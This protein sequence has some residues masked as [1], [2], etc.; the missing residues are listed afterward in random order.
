MFASYEFKYGDEVGLAHM[1]SV[2]PNRLARPFRRIL[3]G[4]ENFMS[5][6]PVTKV[7]RCIELHLLGRDFV[8]AKT[9]S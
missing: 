4:H 2:L 1:Q 9:R 8:N 3:R 7:R 6:A 5:L